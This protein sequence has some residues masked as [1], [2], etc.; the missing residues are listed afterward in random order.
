MAIIRHPILVVSIVFA[1]LGVSCAET[2]TPP[3][4]EAPDV[5][6]PADDG[7]ARGDVDASFDAL[8]DSGSDTSHPSDTS[9]DAGD[10]VPDVG[11]TGGDTSAPDDTGN[12]VP[13]GGGDA[14]VDGGR[15]TGDQDAGG[16][17][18]GDD[19]GDVGPGVCAKDEDCPDKPGMQKICYMN[20]CYYYDPC[21]RDQD[22]VKD[23]N[24][25]GPDCDPT[26]R[27][28][29]IDHEICGNG[30]DDDCN[31]KIDGADPACTPKND[32]CETAQEIKDGEHVAAST[33]GAK[34]DYGTFCGPDVIY[35]FAAG[36]NV[37]ATVTMTVLAPT[38]PQEI[39]PQ[40]VEYEFYTGDT[41]PPYG[42]GGWCRCASGPY[43]GPQLPV[44][45]SACSRNPAGTYYVAVKSGPRNGSPLNPTAGWPF[46][47]DLSLIPIP[48]PACASAV[49][50]S[51]GGSFP[52]D[53][54]DSRWVN[55]FG[56]CGADGTKEAIFRLALSS[57]KNVMIE[58]TGS[59][60]EE[61]LLDDCGTFA[62]HRAERPPQFDIG[63]GTYFIV[64]ELLS[65]Q[66][67]AAFKLTL[68]DPG[69]ACA[70]AEQIAGTVN[71]S[72]TT[73]GL[74][75]KIVA[76][77]GHGLGPEKV[78]RLD[79]A[80]EKRVVGDLIPSYSGAILYYEKECGVSRTSSFSTFRP[81]HFD[82]T[83]PAGTY[84]VVV[85]GD[86]PGDAGDYVLNVTILAP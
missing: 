30:V 70:G 72:G 46:T 44:D 83:L 71:L 13:D 32:T 55:A 11:G 19:A 73:L 33:D 48:E 38:P 9:D 45:Y 57:S 8:F 81:K 61:Y 78:Y 82:E 16:H 17:D 76:G 6:S 74:A 62:A 36:N 7:A 18:G 86:S 1:A 3:G 22:G 69:T 75:N 29:P 65:T 5:L 52:L 79:L 25:G 51:A 64:Q 43:C 21:D 23:N 37:D 56:V 4:G 84:F 26:N 41:C 12:P 77:G 59:Q 20:T 58:V 31:Q 35:T 66:P 63:A 54:A 2:N 47:L 67:G 40:G 80:E 60:G 14:G 39:P 50:I 49:D 15:D 27:D 28:I 53:P 68:S 85:D 42:T 34:A 24:C 10:V